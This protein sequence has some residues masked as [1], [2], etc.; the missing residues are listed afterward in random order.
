MSLEH[1]FRNLNDI[2]LFDLFSEMDLNKDESIDIDE[3][4]ELLECGTKETIQIEDSIN[5]LVKE[6]IL[7]I[8]LVED[9]W[10]SGCKLCTYTDQFKL[11]RFFG[12]ESHVIETK[13]RTITEEY[14]LAKNNV[15][16]CLISAVMTSSFLNAKDIEKN[17]GE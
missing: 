9:D 7:A 5:H 14:Y 10:N 15:V 6:H 2:R 8:N 1:I 3:I 4:I 13:G 17:E 12:H 16:N 11:P